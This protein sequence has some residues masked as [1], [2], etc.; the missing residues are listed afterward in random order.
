VLDAALALF[1]ERGIDATS[2][3]AIAQASGVS[4]ATIYKHWPDKDALC[5]EAMGHLLGRDQPRPVSDSGDLRADLIALLS[6]EPPREYPELRMR[7]MP[8]LWAYAARNPSFGAAW[9][10]RVVEP[11]RAQIRQLLERSIARGQLE[12][13]LDLDFAIVLLLG[14]VMYGHLLRRIHGA[15]PANLP[16]QVVD[17]FLKAHALTPPVQKRRLSRARSRRHSQ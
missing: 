8:H 9:G 12:P 7:I 15:A 5:L 10:Q 11:P 1:A 13:R 14:P 4:K 3:D 17:T 2:M 16:E 6:Y